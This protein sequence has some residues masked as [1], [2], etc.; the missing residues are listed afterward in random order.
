M[1]EWRKTA[2]MGFPVK[3]N[4]RRRLLNALLVCAI[5]TGC[6]S[7]QQTTNYQTPV[8]GT[9][10]AHNFHFRSGETLPVVNLHYRTI[11]V[12]QRDAHGHVS[13][14]VI[15]LHGT[16]GTGAQFLAPYFADVL[17]GPGQPLDATRYYIILPDSIGTGGSSKPSDGLHARF[18]HYDYADMVD[19]QHLMLTEGLHVDH[20]RLVMGTSMGCMH[21]WMWGEMYPDFSDALMPLACQTVE[22]AGRNRMMR[23]ML[24]DAITNDPAWNHG[25]YTSQPPGIRTSLEMLLIMGSSPLQ[26]QVNYPTREAAD[27]YLDSYLQTHMT[28]ADANDMLYQFDSSRDY[29]PSAKLSTIRVPVMYVN[30][31]DDFVNPPELKTAEKNIKLISHGQFVL[32][33][34][35]DQTRGH[36]THTMAAIWKQYLVQILEESKLH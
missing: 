3:L 12:P 29:D 35:T 18:P 15:V 1:R 23:K 20:L 28:K 17:F 4:V 32:L 31:A 33:P 10:V 21:A 27:Q 5:Y 25:D 6:T 8:E 9:Y 2:V 30:S 22:I 19:G 26:M 36:G 24:M 11:G 7:A 34:I 13:N 14:A 16:G